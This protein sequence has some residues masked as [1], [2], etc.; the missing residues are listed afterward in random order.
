[1]NWQA[2]TA[3]Q[4]AWH[5]SSAVVIWPSGV[6]FRIAQAIGGDVRRFHAGQL[7]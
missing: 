7:R 3:A 2:F 4:D 1:M 5:L 6:T